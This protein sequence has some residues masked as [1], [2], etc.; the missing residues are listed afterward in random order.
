VMGNRSRP[1]TP[2]GA[3]LALSDLQVHREFA[4]RPTDR[5]NRGL[6]TK[7]AEEVLWA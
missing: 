2:R 5:P 6:A 1:A 7:L 3:P 4:D